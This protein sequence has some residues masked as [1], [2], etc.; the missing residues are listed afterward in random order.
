MAHLIR[1]GL[2]TTVYF[3]YGRTT[4]LWVHHSELHSGREH[5]SGYVPILA[6]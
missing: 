3:Q 2:T 4:S 5:I 6:T 1:I